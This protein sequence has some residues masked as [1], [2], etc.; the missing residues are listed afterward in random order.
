VDLRPLL[1]TRIANLVPGLLLAFAGAMNWL[2]RRS[3]LAAVAAAAALALGSWLA[4]RGYRMGVRCES[5]V[6]HIRGMVWSRRIDVEWVLAVTDFPAVSWRAGSG[7]RRWSPIFAFFEL[8]GLLP[9]VARHNA[10]CIERLQAWDR[11]RR[12]REERT[13]TRRRRRP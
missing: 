9:F 2:E 8:D 5:G 3:D 13:T 7:R 11:H 6:V 1:I 4:F 10:A 12:R